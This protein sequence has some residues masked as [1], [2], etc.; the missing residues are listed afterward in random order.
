VEGMMIGATS[1][2]GEDGGVEESQGCGGVLGIACGIA[3]VI[4]NVGGSWISGPELAGTASIVRITDLHLE[5]VSDENHE[6]GWVDD[7]G[8]GWASSNKSEQESEIPMPPWFL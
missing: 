8:N 4:W 2:G 7:D 6:L 1:F 5:H 3:V